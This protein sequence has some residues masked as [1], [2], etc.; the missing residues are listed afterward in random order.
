LKVALVAVS[1]GRDGPPSFA[2]IDAGGRYTFDSV[3]PGEYKLAVVDGT[4]LLMQGADGLEQYGPVIQV[5]KV[6]AGE[7]I[8]R[9]PSIF[10][11]Q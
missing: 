5:V 10:K 6:M 7:S 2:D 3:I 8:V 9:N 1:P 11:Q 4:D